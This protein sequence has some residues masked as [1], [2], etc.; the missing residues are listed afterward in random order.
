VFCGFAA[1]CAE[2]LWLSG[3]AVFLKGYASFCARRSL[4]MFNER[5]VSVRLSLTAHQAAEPLA[6]AN[7]AGAQK[8]N[9]DD[10]QWITSM[11]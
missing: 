3:L 6:T 2:S 4:A 11:S 8:A 1:R 9:Y 10:P 7:F 5:L